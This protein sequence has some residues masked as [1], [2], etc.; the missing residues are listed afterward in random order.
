[1]SNEDIIERLTDKV[2]G[3]DRSLTLI[4]K[5]VEDINKSLSTFASATQGLEKNMTKHWAN[6]DLQNQSLKNILEQIADSKTEFKEIAKDR[7]HGCP[8]FTSFEGQRAVEIKRYEEKIVGYDKAHVKHR[9]EI[10]VLQTCCTS[11]TERINVAN[12]RIKDLEA[13]QTKGMWLLVT[14][15]IGIVVTLVKSS[16]S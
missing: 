5:S 2:E 9:E 1:M 11:Q 4:A 10:K 16:M 7:L 12:N 14:A 6:Q 13:N 3:H 8:K 15:F